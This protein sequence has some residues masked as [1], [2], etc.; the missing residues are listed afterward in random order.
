MCYF[1]NRLVHEMVLVAYGQMP[2]IYA[3]AGTSTKARGINFGLSLHL[4]PYIV[5]TSGKGSGESAHTLR[6]T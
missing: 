1:Y 3:H 4:H 5:Y 2:L 6:L